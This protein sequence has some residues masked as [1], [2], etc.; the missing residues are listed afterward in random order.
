[1][2]YSLQQAADA[3]GVNKSTVLRAIQ[4][5]KVSAIRSEHGQW[6]IE[7]AELHRVYP[8]AVAGNG[9]HASAGNDAHLA[10][11]ADANQRAAMAEREV[12]LLRATID[13]LRCDR[14]AWR[15]QAQRLALPAPASG[16]WAWWWRR[17]RPN[18]E[19]KLAA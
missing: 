1:M 10:D 11:L 18:A 8:P 16:A 17:S 6:V 19:H 3:A 13:D 7:P 9:K 14:N 4:G 12:A 2:S 5:G 15:E